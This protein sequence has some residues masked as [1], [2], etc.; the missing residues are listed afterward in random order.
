MALQYATI[1]ATAR[2]RSSPDP[3][4]DSASDEATYPAFQLVA[5]EL[6]TRVDLLIA[7]LAAASTEDRTR[8]A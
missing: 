8:H 2:P 7:E 5:D 3:A 6:E 4:A 1:P